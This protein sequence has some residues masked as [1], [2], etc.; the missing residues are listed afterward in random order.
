MELLLGALKN[1]QLAGHKGGGHVLSR[2]SWVGPA[3]HAK[4][5]PR[6]RL[7]SSRQVANQLTFTFACAFRRS[8]Q[9]FFILCETAFRAA[10]DIR[11]VRLPAV[12]ID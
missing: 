11:L 5:P 7:R 9:Y 12:A 4:R 8:A 6:K 2:K 10:A 1:Q 3:F